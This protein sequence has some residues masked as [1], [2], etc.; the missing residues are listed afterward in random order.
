[1]EQSVKFLVTPS[2]HLQS[3][4]IYCVIDNQAQTESRDLPFG[5]SLLFVVSTLARVS[6]KICTYCAT[7]VYQLIDGVSLLPVI[8]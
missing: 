5:P 1:M 4:S 6:I 7:S 2:A 3:A 8:A